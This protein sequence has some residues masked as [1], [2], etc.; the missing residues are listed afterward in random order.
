MRGMVAKRIVPVA[1]D[2]PED[3]RAHRR[4]PARIGPAA[5]S[6]RRDG[7]ATLAGF[8]ERFVLGAGLVLPLDAVKQTMAVLAPRGG[9]KTHAA[10]VLVEEMVADRLPVVILDPSGTWHGLSGSTDGA[11]PGLPVRILGGARG[12][13]EVREHS[14]AFVADCAI[15]WQQP[16]VVDLSSLSPGGVRRLVSDFAR[17]VMLRSPRI[18]HVVVESAD[19]LFAGTGGQAGP[20]VELLSFAERSG[21]IGFTL[22]SDRPSEISPQI[23]EHVEVLVAARTRS[24]A[25]HGPIR[26]WLKTRADAGTARRILESLPV[27]EAD[28]AWVCSPTWLRAFQRVT[29]R[30]RATYDG[31]RLNRLRPPQSRASAAELRRLR[32]RLAGAPAAEPPSPVAVNTP[33]VTNLP[34][35]HSDGSQRD[36]ERNLADGGERAGR[37][38]RGR[39]IERLVLTMSE[40]A[41]LKRY[42]TGAKCSAQLALRAQIVLACAEGRLNSDVA[43]DLCVT[44]WTVGRWRRRFV[45]ERLRGLE[46]PLSSIPLEP[47]EYA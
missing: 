3:T 47:S 6:A 45:Q 23:L 26:S 19:E 46:L 21:A 22:V 32:A 1:N 40:R 41:A 8:M 13:L 29:L 14:G 28:E 30:H 2:G 31:A 38:R 4:E 44:N 11:G 16:L 39:P 12:G 7:G 9:A 34:R 18:L 36:L 10:T 24:P 33:T 37:P 27:L 35:A 25:E 42:A 15:D 43:R 17:Q 5:Q 20:L